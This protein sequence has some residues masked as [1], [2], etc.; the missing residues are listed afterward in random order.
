MFAKVSPSVGL[1]LFLLDN[2]QMHSASQPAWA[3]SPEAGSV[4]RQQS[5]LLCIAWVL[6]GYL[7]ADQL[8]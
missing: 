4:G 8:Q 7:Q 1:D 3:A 2:D 6:L 5:H